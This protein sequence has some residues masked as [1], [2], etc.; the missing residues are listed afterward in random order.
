M[1]PFPILQAAFEA[2]RSEPRHEVTPQALHAARSRAWVDALGVEL[3][4]VYADDDTVR[5]FTKG[6]RSNRR[7]FGLTELLYD[8][9]V[10]RVAPVPSAAQGKTL[11]YVREPLWQ[12]ESEFA[13]NSFE[14]LKDFNKL[15]LGAAPTKV[16]VGPQVHDEEAFIG[17]L[18]PAAMRCS[19][20]VH[21]VLVPHP[22]EWDVP[23]LPLVLHTLVGDRW[24]HRGD[25]G[26]TPAR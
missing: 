14:A 15:V 4:R 13:K 24:V 26:S 16:F 20:T 9:C 18:L 1:D 6:D 23:S 8:V 5:V 12:V 2:A 21:C 10:C 19:G 22:S 25:S 7:D 11:W 3:R 17:V